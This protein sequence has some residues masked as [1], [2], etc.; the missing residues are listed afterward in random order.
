L[1]LSPDTE[2]EGINWN[3]LGIFAKNR[4]EWAMVDLACLRSDIT[5]VP[6]Y[7]SLG[8]DALALVLN[9]TEVATMCVEKSIFDTLVKLRQTEC[10]HLQNVVVFDEITEEQREQAKAA[11][12]NV[13]HF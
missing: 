12:L 8:K 3:F 6:F 5:I 7:D 11:G 13:Y 4:E 10:K 1:K 2:G 9:T